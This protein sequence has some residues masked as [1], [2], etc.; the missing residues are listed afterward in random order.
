MDGDSLG[1]RTRIVYGRDGE[2]LA[3]YEDGELVYWRD[4]KPSDGLDGIR[5]HVMKDIQPYK[6]MLTG[7][8][9]TSRSRHR[10]HLRDHGCVEVGN[11]SSAL[12]PVYK[13]LTPPPG[14]KDKVVRAYQQQMEKKRR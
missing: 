1:M 10:E 14:L 2:H 9:I 6:S 4:E 3:R 7:E 12:N 11:D 5:Q 13:G 8:E